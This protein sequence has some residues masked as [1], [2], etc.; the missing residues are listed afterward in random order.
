MSAPSPP[1]QVTEEEQPR[2]V[3]HA[4]PDHARIL[5]VDWMIGNSC[6]HACSYCPAQL[7]DGSLTWQDA[8]LIRNMYRQLKRHY[9]EG[10]GQSVWLQ[11][12]G[13]EPTMHPQIVPLLED[14]KDHG[15]KASIISNGS[16]TLRFWDRVCGHLDAAI[17]TYHSEFVDHEHFVSVAGLLA[18]SMPVHINVTLPPETFDAVFARAEDIGARLPDV[19]I[20]L[21]PLRVGFGDTLYPYSDDQLA[22]LD[23]RITS[24]DRYDATV[25]R[26]VMVREFPSGAYDVQRANAMI[27]A[28]ENR[29]KGMICSAGIEALR[30]HADGRVTR[31]VCAAG[32]QIGRLGEELALPTSPVRCPQDTCACVADILITKRALTAPVAAT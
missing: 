23:T 14:A 15:F 2:L 9:V 28:G 26:T 21:K 1:V 6:N 29:W 31:A 25:P 32:G 3:R 7:H 12:T 19:T 24:I 5:L 4:N 8:R 30:I 10:L 16:R 22:R 17:L 13:G 18:D 11:F 20:A 27:V